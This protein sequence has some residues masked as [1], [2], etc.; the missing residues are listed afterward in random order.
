MGSDEKA[1]P[2][3]RVKKVCNRAEIHGYKHD[4]DICFDLGVLIDDGVNA[5]MLVEGGEF[6]AT[7][8]ES[9][10]EQY[11]KFAVRIGPHESVLLH[12]GLTFQPDEGYG[13]K[14]H[15]RSSTGIKKGLILS[16]STGIID[17]GYR[18]EVMVCLYNTSPTYSVLVTDG[19]RVA[20]CEVVPVIQSSIVEVDKLDDTDRG[21]GG[22]G[23]TG[24]H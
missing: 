13:I 9:S 7:E 16:N 17:S 5:P 22:F 12:T 6:N 19:E 4:G 2:T 14:V 8:L 1:I 21:A 10:K 11:G 20:Q 18:G 15:V 3:V 23:S 24:G